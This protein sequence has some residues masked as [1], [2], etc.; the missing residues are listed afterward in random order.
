MPADKDR[1]GKLA[2]QRQFAQMPEQC[3]LGE[4]VRVLDRAVYGEVSRREHVC[5]VGAGSFRNVHEQ[6]SRLVGEGIQEV[7]DRQAAEVARAQQLLAVLSDV[8]AGFRSRTARR[9]TK[10]NT[11]QVPGRHMI[12]V[13]SGDHRVEAAG[14]LVEGEHSEEIAGVSRGP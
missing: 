12:E 13:E 14:A 8:C 7:A 11:I 3:V 1:I 9:G 4:P 2:G 5:Q 6:K 10:H